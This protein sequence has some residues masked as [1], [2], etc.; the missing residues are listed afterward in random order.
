MGQ[1]GGPG[2]GGAG[3]EEEGFKSKSDVEVE[4]LKPTL[5]PPRAIS[6]VYCVVK[7]M[8]YEENDTCHHISPRLLYVVDYE[9]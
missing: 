5:P 3:R 8:S 7:Y 1:E 6:P 2:G 4:S 9:E